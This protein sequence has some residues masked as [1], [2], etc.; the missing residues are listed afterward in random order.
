[1]T[2]K[3]KKGKLNK[4]KNTSVENI[5]VDSKI[6]DYVKIYENVIDAD[7]CEAI[8]GEYQ[9]SEDWRNISEICDSYHNVKRNYDIMT[10]SSMDSMLKNI[11]KRKKIDESIFDAVSKSK[12]LYAEE[13]SH[14]NIQVDTGF[15]LLKYQE[16]DYYNQHIDDFIDRKRSIACSIQLNDN[17]DGGEF[18]FFDR[19]VVMKLPKASMI[20]FPS[21]FMYPHEI[22]SVK[23]GI[24]YSVVT[25]LI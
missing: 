6:I 8:V 24:R 13:F 25:W 23:K 1:M 14:L 16:G 5:L 4:V 9:N 10:I 11:E 15:D 19:K 2:K 18:A 12:D 21:N 7:L 20:M 17:Y 22:L 3:K